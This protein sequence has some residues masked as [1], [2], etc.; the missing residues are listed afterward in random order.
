VQNADQLKRELLEKIRVLRDNFKGEEKPS[1]L[2]LLR[3][4]SQ[5]AC[6]ARIKYFLERGKPYETERQFDPYYKLKSEFATLKILELLKSRLTAEGLNVTI[7][8]EAPSDVGRHDIA[9]IQRNPCNA[10]DDKKVR[11]E[12]KASLGLDFEQLGR[13]LWDP[14]PVILARVITGHIVRLDPSKLQSYIVLCLKELNAKADRLISGKIIKI[15]GME[16]TSCHASLCEHNRR[17]LSSRTRRLITMSDEALNEDLN[18]FLKNLCYVAE[19]TVS[20]AIEE[21]KSAINKSA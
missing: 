11:I 3:V 15:S 16:C 4:V 12:V 13:Y 19:K 6:E 21:F 17:K 20:L 8:T 9:L 1:I 14:S 5:D 18:L 10:G 2:S 7:L